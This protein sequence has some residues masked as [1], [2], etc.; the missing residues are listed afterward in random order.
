MKSIIFAISYDRDNTK[1]NEPPMLQNP[2]TTTGVEVRVAPPPRQP[3]SD[4]PTTLPPVSSPSQ[5]GA[6]LLDLPPLVSKQVVGN[7][8]EL[9]QFSVDDL[10]GPLVE[11]QDN[12]H[13]S[14]ESALSPEHAEGN[15]SYDFSSPDDHEDTL[16]Y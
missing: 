14:K 13:R 8:G 6:W 16:R 15:Y 7:R 9:P 5:T 10:L 11:K 2:T 4:P 1:T 3:T 12:P